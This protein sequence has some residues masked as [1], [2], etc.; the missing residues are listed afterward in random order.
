VLLPNSGTRKSVKGSGSADEALKA[1]VGS[2]IIDGADPVETMTAAQTT[3]N[4]ALAD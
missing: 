2:I 3:A 1:A 4:A